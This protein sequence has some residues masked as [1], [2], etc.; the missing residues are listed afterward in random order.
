MNAPDAVTP[1]V[2]S[3]DVV[4]LRLRPEHGALHLEVLLVRRLPP[5]FAWQWALPGAVLAADEL[6]ADC[7]RRLLRERTGLPETYLEQLYT[8][9]ALDRDPRGRTL[10]VAYYALY[11]LD[12]P[13][14]QPGRDVAD[15]RW[16]PVRHLP[17]GGLLA[18]D[19]ARIIRAAHERL[20][21]KLDYAPVA[22]AMLPPTFTMTQLR[23]VYE[24]IQERD[25]DPTNFPRAMQARFPGLT[26]VEGQRDRTTRRPAR[27]F[28]HDAPASSPPPNGGAP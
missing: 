19:H 27:L 9:D 22:F 2:V 14:L 13:H 26:L 23:H 12:A 24:A 21:N 17:A 1:V 18:F 10:S 11:R 28:R 4:G 6:L 8:F 25:Y 15:V 5:P 7:A 20:R 3:A 16:W